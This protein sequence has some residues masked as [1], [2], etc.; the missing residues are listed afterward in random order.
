M[1]GGLNREAAKPAKC[2]TFSSSW[3]MVH[4]LHDKVAG[5]G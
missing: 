2:H 3:L 5:S 1:P 4:I